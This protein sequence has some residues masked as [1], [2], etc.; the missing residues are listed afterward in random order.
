[1]S[2]T[3]VRFLLAFSLIAWL[4][5]AFAAPSAATYEALFPPGEAILEEAHLSLP[6]PLS[7]DQAFDR[8]NRPETEIVVTY[9]EEDFEG[10]FPSGLW[11]VFDKDGMA[12]G[13]YYWGVDD[14]LPGSGSG[15]AWAA[16]SGADGLD[17]EFNNYPDDADSWMIYGPVD[18]SSVSSAEVLFDYYNDSEEGYDYFSW[19]ASVDGADFYGYKVSGDSE[20][21]ASQVFDLTAVPTLGDLS[22][23]AAVWVGFVF[24]SD[25]S[26]TYPGPFVDNIVFHGHSGDPDP[27]VSSIVRID[28][29]PTQAPA[30]DFRVTFSEDVTGVDAGD[31]TLTVV[32][33]SG[34]GVTDLSGSGQTYTV[35]VQTGTGDGTLRLDL[36]DD[37]SI[38]DNL[39]QPLGGVGPG[40]GSYTSGEA[41]TL[42]H[43]PPAVSSIT[44]AG[45]SPT[46]AT[47]LKFAVQ[48]DEAVSGLDSSDFSLATSGISGASIKTVVGSGSDYVV[49][50][51]S[52]TGDGTIRLDLTDDDSIADLAG[53]A[54]GG[55]G[56]GNGDFSVGESYTLDRS[57]HAWESNGPYGGELNCLAKAPTSLDVMYAGSDSGMYKSTNNGADWFQLNFAEI[58][59]HS[60]QVSPASA[61]VVYAGT[62]DGIYRS[63]DGGASWTDLGLAE[64]QVNAIAIHPTNPNI[65]L[66]GTGWLRVS[67][68]SEIVGIFKSE[69]GGST[70]NLKDSNNLDTVEAIL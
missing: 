35:T 57:L 29:N 1:M 33:L 65:V 37:D 68:E 48:F 13:E 39:A 66:A 44:R 51:N 30:V 45:A 7:A 15:S 67:S 22:G 5:V 16:R 60:C 17:P 40:N 53:N 14:Y 54:L 3:S 21:W 19:M 31:F 18:L 49:K 46:G 59:V 8:P 11:Q 50:V 23:A 12:N 32:G 36:V 34:T 69:D 4:A 58:D 64:A 9:V 62:G 38:V 43:T 52:G 25:G 47:T 28:A 41:Y 70:W 10:A 61:D 55:S 26:V 42:D 24:Q 20:Y 56:A 6:E 2:R 63:M 27:V